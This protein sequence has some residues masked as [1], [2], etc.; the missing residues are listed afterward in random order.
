HKEVRT[1][2]RQTSFTATVRIHF[3]SD[4][5]HS[6]VPVEWINDRHDRCF[7]DHFQPW[8]TDGDRQHSTVPGELQSPGKTQ[9]LVRCVLWIQREKCFTSVEQFG[10]VERANR[11]VRQT[12]DVVAKLAVHAPGQSGYTI[13]GAGKLRVTHI[14]YCV[15]CNREAQLSKIA[16]YVH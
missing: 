4:Q 2:F 3:H 6:Q 9:L 10:T 15:A 12:S 1:C 8:L 5:L 14:T 11:T 13:G 16:F 7:F